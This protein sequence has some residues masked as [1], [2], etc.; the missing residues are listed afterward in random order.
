LL[1]YITRDY[2]M[3]LF[4]QISRGIAAKLGLADPNESM[5]LLK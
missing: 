5:S 3:P 4:G 1:K 2:A